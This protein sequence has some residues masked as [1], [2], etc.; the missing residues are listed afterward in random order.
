MSISLNANAAI[1]KGK[2]ILVTREKNRKLYLLPGGGIKKDEDPQQAL[3]RELHE[4]LGIKIDNKNLESLGKFSAPKVGRKT[5]RETQVFI[6][7][8]WS[9]EILPQ[10]EVEA[11]EWINSN[12][13]SLSLEWILKHLVIP[14]LREKGI[15]Y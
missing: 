10:G 3:I 7:K 13:L 6:V 8:K 12:N 5:E 2:K 11:I 9:G 14:K 15:I 1:L 4:E